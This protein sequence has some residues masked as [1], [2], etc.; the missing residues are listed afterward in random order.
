MHTYVAKLPNYDKTN[1]AYYSE[2]LVTQLILRQ[3]AL[4]IGGHM[5]KNSEQ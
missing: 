3:N 1:Y 5:Y 4:F 2:L